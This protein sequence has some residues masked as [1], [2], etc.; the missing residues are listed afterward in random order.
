MAGGRSKAV[1]RIGIFAKAK[2]CRANMTNVPIENFTK[3][4]SE[5]EGEYPYGIR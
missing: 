5:V 4:V 1:K 2:K 3:K